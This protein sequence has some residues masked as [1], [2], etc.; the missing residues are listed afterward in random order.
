M[1]AILVK[2]DGLPK[3]ERPFSVKALVK[4]EKERVDTSHIQVRMV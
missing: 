3:N 1:V 4:K 2:T